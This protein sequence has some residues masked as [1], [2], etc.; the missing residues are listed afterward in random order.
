M[1]TLT[2]ILRYNFIGSSSNVQIKSEEDSSKTISKV[3]NVEDGSKT[4]ETT[5][6]YTYTQIK[7]KEQLVLRKDMDVNEHERLPNIT[8]T[9]CSF[10][11][12]CV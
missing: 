10:T 11:L 7:V 3:K 4:R 5:Q 9:S 8:H 1:W 6:H 2:K 12:I